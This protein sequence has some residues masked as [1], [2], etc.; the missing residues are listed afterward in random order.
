MKKWIRIIAF[1][2]LLII[3]VYLRLKPIINQ[4]V[5]YTYDQGRDFL[6]AEEIVRFKNL[7]FIGPTTGIMGINHGAWWYYLLSI[8]YFIFNCWPMGF[9]YFMFFISLVGNLCFYYFLK[10]EFN[11]NT[12]LLFLSIVS[13]S[14]YF[15]PLSFFASNNIITPYIILFLI[16]SIYYLFKTKKYIWFFFLALSSGFVHEF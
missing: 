7:T 15:I 11:L 13:I 8:P 1:L 3:F 2:S 6:K 4:T 10:K 9:Y 12:A 5:P 16:V 14:P